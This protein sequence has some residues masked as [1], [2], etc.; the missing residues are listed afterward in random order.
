LRGTCW[1]GY[2]LNEYYTNPIHNK[3]NNNVTNLIEEDE[4]DEK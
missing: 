3:A 1:L 2:K 4:L